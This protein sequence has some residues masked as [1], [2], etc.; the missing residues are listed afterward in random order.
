MSKLIRLEIENVK[1]LKAIRIEPNGNLVI[2]GGRNGAGKTCV[3]DSIEYLLTGKKSQPARPVRDGEDKATIT[4]YLDD[5]VIK[6]TITAAGATALVIT[7]ADGHK[8]SSPQTILDSLVA[9]LLDPLAFARMEPARQVETL[10]YLVGLDVSALDAEKTALYDDRT[11]VNRKLR[12]AKGSLKKFPEIPKD[13]PDEAIDVNQLVN[14]SLAIG[15]RNRERDEAVRQIEAADK[16]VANAAETLKR[17]KTARDS[18]RQVFGDLAL[19]VHES[20]NEIQAEIK[21]AGEINKAVVIRANRKRVKADIRVMNKATDDLSDQLEAVNRRKADIMARVSFPVDGLGLGDGV[22][23][24]RGLPFDQASSA[25]Q[26]RVSVAMALATNPKLKVLLIRDGSLLDSD[27]LAI[28]GEMAE[29]ADADVW[30]ERVGTDDKTAV[31]I[32]DGM[33]ME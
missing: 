14:E 1:K 3:L 32:E 26:L 4:G 13:T 5:L 22:V 25:E 17:A 29:A 30:I 20:I 16:L 18:A 28:V 12:D 6:R 10:R 19:S 27:S 7:N 24:Y 23:T 31:I 8:R 11:E 2:I 21:S 33:V 15:E 9:K